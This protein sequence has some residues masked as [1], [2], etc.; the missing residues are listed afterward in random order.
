MEFPKWVSRTHAVHDEIKAW[1]ASCIGN[2]RARP[3][4]LSHDRNTLPEDQISLL[5]LLSASV[6][7][8]F[9]FTRNLLQCLAPPS[10][11]QPVTSTSFFPRVPLSRAMFIQM[12]D[13]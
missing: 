12:R 3:F 13:L 4:A 10:G 6:R 2:E 8:L 5:M 1:S 11:C 7:A 9:L